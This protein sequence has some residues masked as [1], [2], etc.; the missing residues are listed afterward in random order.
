MDDLDEIL[1]GSRSPAIADVPTVLAVPD[2]DDVLNIALNDEESSEVSLSQ[3]QGSESQKGTEDKNAGSLESL[4]REKVGVQVSAELELSADPSL[5]V[6]IEASYEHEWSSTTTTSHEF[7]VSEESRE[8]AQQAFANTIS[9]S[10]ASSGTVTKR[11]V[12]R[13]TSKLTGLTIKDMRVQLQYVC[14]PA[15]VGKPQRC[16]TP[17]KRTTL[18]V[19]LKPMGDVVIPANSTKAVVMTAK[20]VSAQQLKDIISAPS[21]VKFYIENASLFPSG[22]QESLND[23]IGQSVPSATASLTIDDGNGT[24]IDKIIAVNLDREWGRPDSS[25]AP[26][27][28]LP[29]DPRHA[30]HR[31]R[32][33][34][35]RHDPGDR[36]P[37]RAR[38]QAAHRPREDRGRVA[39]VR[40]GPGPRR[41]AALRRARPQRRRQRRDHVRQRRRRR[42]PLQP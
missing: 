41:R 32:I 8:T 14:L 24:V 1:S 31:A 26:P 29:R 20:N 38:Q 27:T 9:Q 42:R 15:Q 7:T 6:G 2:P 17:G 34:R 23:T 28:P 25:Q 30:R 13:N 11:F 21:N 35:A 36:Q 4:D 3:E 39:A 19:P 33:R 37:Q 12:V 22:S 10:T 16:A 18:G 40:R 5:T